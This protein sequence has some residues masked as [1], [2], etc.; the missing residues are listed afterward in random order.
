MVYDHADQPLTA[1]KT[2][3]GVVNRDTTNEGTS[4]SGEAILTALEICYQVST[5]NCNHQ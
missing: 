3:V 4:Y 5:L 2:L 1:G